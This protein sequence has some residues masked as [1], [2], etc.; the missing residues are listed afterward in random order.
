MSQRWLHGDLKDMAYFYNFKVF[1]DVV[2]KGVDFRPN[3]WGRDNQ[4]FG[5]DWLHGDLKDM[6]FF[7]N[8]KLFE[9][10]VVKGVLK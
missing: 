6:A 9:D 2:T 8:H 5:T 10:I 1:E 7:Y 3:G 4:R